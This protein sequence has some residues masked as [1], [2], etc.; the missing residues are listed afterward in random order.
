V[1][2]DTLNITKATGTTPKKICY[3]V[4]ADWKWQ[5]WLKALEKSVSAKVAQKDLMKE[6]MA[7]AEMRAKAEK[8]SKFTAQITDDLNRM[9]QERKKRLLQVKL[10]DEAQALKEAKNFFEKELNAEVCI[11]DEEDTER[12]DPTSRAHVAKPGRP[13]IFIE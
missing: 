2:E 6:L 3:Y 9:A 7:N 8:V 12:Y 11:Y 5:T 1:L 13:A 10:V 4:A